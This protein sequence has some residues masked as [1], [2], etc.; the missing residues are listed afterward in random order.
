[1]RKHH[2]DSKGTV[3]E[4]AIVELNGFIVFLLVFNQYTKKKTQN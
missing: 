4:S 3:M 2:K 1:M